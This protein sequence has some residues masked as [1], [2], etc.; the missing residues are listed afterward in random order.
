MINDLII[1]PRRVQQKLQRMALEILE[2]NNG[3]RVLLAGIHKSG[4]DLAEMIAG[5]LAAFSETGY[6]VYRISI[7]KQRPLENPVTSDIPEEQLKDATLIIVDDVQNSGKTMMYS[8]RHFLNFPLRS[9]QTC[10]L[11]DR[12]HNKFPVKSDYVGISLSTTLQEHVTVEVNGKE[13]EVFLR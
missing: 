11:V 9:V 3:Q 12:S 6:P 5:Y 8:I 2:R 10:V 4:F 13:V 7:N 1:E